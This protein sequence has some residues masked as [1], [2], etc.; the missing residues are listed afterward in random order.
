[1]PTH[2][3]PET[4]VR[5]WAALCLGASSVVL[6]TSARSEPPAAPDP[7][8][9][10]P[11]SADSPTLVRIAFTREAAQKLTALRVRRLV[12]LQL[13]EEFLVDPE[14]AGPLDEA[15]IRIFI[16]L[17]T[18][19]TLRVQGHAPGRRV[20]TRAVDIDGVAAGGA[21]GTGGSPDNA[22]NPPN[23]ASCDETETLLDLA[24]EPPPGVD[25]ALATLDLVRC[26]GA[27]PRPLALLVRGG[28]WGKRAQSRG[29][30]RAQRKPR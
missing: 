26:R 30:Y 1:V 9:L 14:P 27:E 12:E 19:T 29:N 3:D 7:S 25:G 16:E 17:D 20:E 8:V 4:R 23:E 2:D 24:Y 28:S 13:G 11:P 10:A 21:G 5:L 15:S 6:T 18:P 22:P